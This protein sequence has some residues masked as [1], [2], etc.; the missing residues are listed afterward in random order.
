MYNLEGIMLSEGFP[1]SSA[2]KDSTCN[3]GDPGSIPGFGRA[4]GGRHGNPLQNSCL[5]NPHGKEP[6]GLQPMP[7]CKESDTTEQLSIEH[8]E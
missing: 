1:G 4:P 3:A 2:G 7:C 5:G 6:N 8:A